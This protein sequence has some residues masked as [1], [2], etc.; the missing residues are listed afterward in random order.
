MYNPTCVMTGKRDNLQMYA[1]RNDKGEM[2][3]WV[4]LHEGIDIKKANI[5]IK[6]DIEGTISK[7]TK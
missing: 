5:S 3:G 4:F 7:E 2:V 1:H 6:V